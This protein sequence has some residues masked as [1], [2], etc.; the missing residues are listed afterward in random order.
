MSGDGDATRSRPLVLCYRVIAMRVIIASGIY[1][2]DIGGPALYAEGVER[3]LQTMGHETQLA[4]FGPFRKYPTGIRHIFYTFDLLKAARNADAILA[5]DTYSVGVPSVFV[6]L[7]LRKKVVIRI[8]GDFVWEHYVERTKRPVPL[9]QFYA[10]ARDLALKERLARSLVGWMLRHAELAFNTR[11]LLEIWEPAYGF[12]SSR[13]HVVKN[14]I[15]TRI[16]ASSSDRTVLLFGRKLS[17]K[18]ADALRRAFAKAKTDLKLEEGT[19]SHEKFLERLALSH[20]VAVPSISDVAP[21]AIIDAIRC[22]KPFLLTK[23]SGYAEEFGQFGVLV[24]PLDEADMARGIEQ[25]ADR[26]LYDA[27]CKK[28]SAFHDVRTYDDVARD[29]LALLN[30]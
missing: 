3:A 5:F 2:P 13:A 29:M 20:A 17:L 7:L 27:L 12:S 6:G 25:L 22:G 11:W 18:N 26:S 14:V 28:I 10:Q 24:D 30:V 4:L 23:Y 21:N 9:P 15:G 19:V 1:P 8:G 16:P